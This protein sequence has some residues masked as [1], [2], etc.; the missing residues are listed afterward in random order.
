MSYSRRQLYAMGEMLGESAT[1]KKAG[2]GMIYGGGGSAPSQ[3]T[4]STTNTSNIPEYA[5]PYVENM[6]GA[7]QKQ[8]FNT[9]T[10]ASGN[11]S[12]TG[13]KPYTPYSTNMQDYF[14]P[15]S[16][17]QNQA[18]GEAQNLQTPG[19]FQ[20]GSGL[21]GIAGM[22]ALGAQSNFQNQATNPG[23]VQAYMSPYIQASLDPQLA[24]MQRQ[25]GI[26]GQQEQSQATGSGAFGG[27]REALMAAENER[28]K[29]IAMNQA[30]GQ[31]YN[32]AFTNAQN[33]MQFG[34]NL[35]MQG[36]NA[37]N[38]AAG[39]L[40]QLGSG[41]SQANLANINAQNQLGNQAQ[42][43]QQGMYNQAIQNYAT[44]QQYPEMQLGFMS[45]M[46]R[47]LPLQATTT[48]TYQAA[49]SAGQQ[50]MGLGLG[51]LGAAKA[52]G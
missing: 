41:Y 22:N 21:A 40:G 8:L 49:P 35:G 11:T 37:A 44:E 29:N 50:A 52:F 42:Q 24:E 47:G 7:T 30:I 3:P 4:T 2:G 18:Y 34:A 26:T 28:N 46:L 13:S 6:L 5:Q 17:L 51:A 15:Q 19:Q 33:Q 25:Y 45:N 23:A 14:A 1:R 10:D 12:L 43:Y 36:V 16:S 39:T 32:T 9:T 38:Q 27:S 48:Q 20:Q 31:G